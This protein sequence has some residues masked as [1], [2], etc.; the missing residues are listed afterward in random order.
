MGERL[1]GKVAIVTGAG[2]GI[3]G[4]TARLMVA[5]GARVVLADRIPESLEPIGAELGEAAVAQV[6]DVSKEDD[7]SGLVDLARSRFGRLDVL[8]NN[9]AI[10]HPEDLDGVTATNAAWQKTFEVVVMAAVWGCRY[11]IPLMAETD[12]GSIVNMSSLA[13]SNATGSHLA[14]GSCKGAI[15]SFTKYIAAMHAPEGIR[16]NAVAP[17][18]VLTPGIEQ[19]FDSASRDAVAQRAA[20]GR[21]CMPDEIAEVVVFLA[22]DAASYLS[23]EVVAVNGAG[24]RVEAW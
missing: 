19:L 20:L 21:I 12:G 13:A 16:C 10:T 4:A 8:H 7:V 1:A 2:G 3:G 23:G 15:Q 6:A 24:Q 17:G 22:S 11:A 14:Y 9:A 5:E 18:F